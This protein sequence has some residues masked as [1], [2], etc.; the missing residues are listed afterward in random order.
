M[1]H[2]NNTTGKNKGKLQ[3]TKLANF[4]GKSEG[5]L[6]ATRKKSE[7]LLSIFHLGSLCVAN[8]I[9]EKQLEQALN[10]GDSGLKDK[11]GNKIFLGDILHIEDDEFEINEDSEVIFKDGCYCFKDGGKLYEV[12]D[13]CE[14][15]VKKST[16]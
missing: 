16:Y 10:Y 1:I 15:K 7:K 9:S 14:V 12:L 4:I 5:A 8:N 11:K 3:L 2:F 13:I 6:R